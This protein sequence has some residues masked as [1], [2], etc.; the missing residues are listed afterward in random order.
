MEAIEEAV[1]DLNLAAPHLTISVSFAVNTVTGLK[2][3]A[4]ETVQT[5]PAENALNAVNGATLRRNAINNADTQAP[6]VLLQR[7]IDAE[8][9]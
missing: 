3:A 5:S 9:G 2:T 1:A 6:V 8:E 7:N 4:R